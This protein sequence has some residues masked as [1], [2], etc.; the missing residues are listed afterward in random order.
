PAGSNPVSVFK[1]PRSPYCQFD[2]QLRGRRFHG[3]TGC[4]ARKEAERFEAVEREKAKALGKAMARARTS[5]LIDDVAARLWDD[6]A[7]YDA[8]PEATS[9][10]IARIVDYFGKSTPLTDIDHASAKKMVAWRRGQRVCRRGKR[11]KK[12]REALPL[13]S[14]AT[15]NRS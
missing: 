6:R 10:N 1:V 9:A 13:V 12:Q 3:S 2:F 11:T 7:Q 5:L 8:A 4:S 15:V 14:N